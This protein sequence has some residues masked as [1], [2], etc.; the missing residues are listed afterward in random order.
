MMQEAGRVPQTRVLLEQFEK[1]LAELETLTAQVENQ[2][3]WAMRAEPTLKCAEVNAKDAVN[4][5]S[6]LVN[7]LTTLDV[8]V[9]EVNERLRKVLEL[10]DV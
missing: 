1:R 9:R 8:Q 3:A 7:R 6:A 2:L 10:L 5:N 4:V